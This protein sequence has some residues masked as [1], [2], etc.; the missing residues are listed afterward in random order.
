MLYSNSN[1]NIQKNR[2]KTTFWT[3]L[4]QSWQNEICGFSDFKKSLLAQL[5]TKV[6]FCGAGR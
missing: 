2:K 6:V 3:V 1:I 5:C 4:R